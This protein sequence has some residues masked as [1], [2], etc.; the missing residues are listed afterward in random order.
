MADLPPF[1]K[2]AKREVT[3]KLISKQLKVMPLELPVEVTEVVE[4]ALIH[5]ANYKSNIYPARVAKYI[6]EE[7]ISYLQKLNGRRN[8]T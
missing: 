7:R 2:P 5:Y 6:K 3:K 1:V 4:R 8:P